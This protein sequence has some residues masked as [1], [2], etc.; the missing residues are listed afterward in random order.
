MG[1]L[2]FIVFMLFALV[3]FLYIVIAN[4]VAQNRE[5]TYLMQ[6]N[7]GL[8]PSKTDVDYWYEKP[9]W[10]VLPNGKKINLSEYMTYEEYKSYSKQKIAQM[11][12]EIAN[13]LENEKN[14]TLTI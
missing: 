10:Y 6:K 12:L 3:Y 5:N 8:Q 13:R 14:T 1:R 11:M 2:V 4:A 7:G 9:H